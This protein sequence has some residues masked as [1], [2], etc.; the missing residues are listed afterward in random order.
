M[1]INIRPWE[2]KDLEQVRAVIWQSWLSTYVHFIPEED[3]SDFFN[4]HYSSRAIR[5]LRRM[6]G[7]YGYVVEALGGTIVGYIR[8]KYDR[9]SRRYYISSLYLLPDFQGQGLG[10]RLLIAAEDHARTIHEVKRVWIGVMRSN[11]RALTWYRKLGFKFTSEE[12]FRMGKTVIPHLIGYRDIGILAVEAMNYSSLSRKMTLSARAADLVQ[13]QR[14]VWELLKNGLE[15]L[16]E[17]RRRTVECNNFSVILQHNPGRIS[18]ATAKIDLVSLA[19][20]PCLLCQANLPKEQRGIDLEGDCQ[21]LCNPAPIFYPHYT[22]CHRNHIPQSLESHM[23]IF[24][25]LAA[26]MGPD[27]LLLY[28]GPTCGASIPDHLHF[29]AIPAGSLPVE[30][31]IKGDEGN[32]AIKEGRTILRNISRKGRAILVA[33]GDEKRDVKKIV[34]GII[35]AMESEDPQKGGRMLNACCRKRDNFWQLIIFPRGKHRPDAYFRSDE[36]RVLVSPGV[37]DMGGVIVLPDQRDFDRLKGTDV[38]DI[39]REVS[40]GNEH[41]E[42]IITRTKKILS[43]R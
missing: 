22:I 12:P 18:N 20:R 37:I 9:D 29:Q 17:C 11:E 33:R 8:T 15:A 36:K 10:G 42:R 16:D 7:V 1:E 21:I 34:Q 30:D 28:N 39:Y 2:E 5:E 14:R 40:I 26:D 41:L 32:I 6:P 25:Q 23:D 19:S 43:G 3:L 13:E 24:L 31:D 4:E 35:F 38:E 27:Y